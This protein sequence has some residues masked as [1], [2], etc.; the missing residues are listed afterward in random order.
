MYKAI[1][2]NIFTVVQPSPQSIIEHFHYLQKKLLPLAITSQPPWAASLRQLLVCLSPYICLFWTFHI[3]WIMYMVF[4]DQFLPLSRMFS[5]FIS[6]YR[7]YQNFIPLHGLIIACCMD[8]P[9]LIYPFTSLGISPVG[10]AH[11]HPNHYVYPF[12]S[13]DCFCIFHIID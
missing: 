10:W 8:I 9:H 5:R 4:C 11:I 12:L 13:L 3:N 7:I 6:I 2:V 1:V